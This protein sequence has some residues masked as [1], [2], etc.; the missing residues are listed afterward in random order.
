MPI[1]NMDTDNSNNDI[2]LGQL[3]AGLSANTEAVKSLAENVKE[4]T[5]AH[6]EHAAQLSDLF[7]KT[8]GQSDD[9]KEIRRQLENNEY[10]SRLLMSM[11]LDP[12]DPMRTRG[13]MDFLHELKQEHIEKKQLSST[14]KKAI[15]VMLAVTILAFIMHSIVNGFSKEVVHQSISEATGEA[16][17]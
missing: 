6:S 14:I 5:Q 13:Y 1:L 3:I 17:K 8:E 2:L 15:A 9:I 11:G 4:L 7:H 12:S 16:A 10:A